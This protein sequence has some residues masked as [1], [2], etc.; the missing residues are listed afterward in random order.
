M[1]TDLVNKTASHHK[2]FVNLATLE[3]QHGN[4]ASGCRFVLCK[5]RARRLLTIKQF[6]AF[7]TGRFAYMN[8]HNGGS[9]FDLRIGIGN[10]VVIPVGVSRLTTL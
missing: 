9:K 7:S 8:R 2:R 6:V 5:H 1:S 4:D 3:Y 10:E